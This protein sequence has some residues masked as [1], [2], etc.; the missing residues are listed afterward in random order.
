MPTRILVVDDQDRLLRVL[1]LGL[2]ELG[3]EVCTADNGEAALKEIYTRAPDI[4]VTDIQMPTM[5]GIEL[6]YEMERLQMDIPT[7]VM[8][9]YA[10]VDSAVRSFKHGAKDYIQKP[11]TVEELHKV[12]KELLVKYPKAQE[13]HFELHEKKDQAERESILKAL[14]AAGNVKSE[15][16]KLLKV[17]ERTL[18]YKLKK[19]GI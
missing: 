8:T 13:S 15:A 14:K 19:Y 18:W 6:V 3:Y 2:K 9:A 4:V 5:S 7:V 17:S 1:R 10:D 16:A 11:F 12:V